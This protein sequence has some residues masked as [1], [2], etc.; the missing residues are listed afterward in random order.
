MENQYALVDFHGNSQVDLERALTDLNQLRNYHSGP[1]ANGL[2]WGLI[3]FYILTDTIARAD[4]RTLIALGHPVYTQGSDYDSGKKLPILFP[5]VSPFDYKNR[6]AIGILERYQKLKSSTSEKPELSRFDGVPMNFVYCS[7]SKRQTQSIFNFYL[8]TDSY[9]SWTWLLLLL[10]FIFVSYL[11]FPTTSFF[12]SLSALICPGTSGV[13]KSWETSQLFVMWMFAC[14]ILCTTYTGCMSSRVIRPSTEDVLSDLADLDR[15]NYA[16]IVGGT[17]ASFI[18][19][20]S[21]PYKLKEKISI[22]QKIF[23]KFPLRHVNSASQI[24]RQ[25]ASERKLAFMASWLY[26]LGMANHMNHLYETG[27]FSGTPMKKCYVGKELIPFAEIHFAV[28]PPGSQALR[29]ILQRLTSSGICIRWIQEIR[30]MVATSRVQD[31]SGIFSPT[32]ILNDN[33]GHVEQLK[34]KE[35]VL[36]IFVLWGTCLIGCLLGFLMEVCLFNCTGFTLV[37]LIETILCRIDKLIFM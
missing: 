23:K 26:A 36:T 30:W 28:T 19:L 9:D 31:R 27:K 33:V 12:S 29:H 13:Q 16:I 17:K 32:K 34:M 22:L 37:I 6:T 3:V 25:L 15:L 24:V 5:Y 10:S 20:K 14:Y 11:S 8:F 21:A 4:N 1:K 18:M 35:R 7:V 2:N